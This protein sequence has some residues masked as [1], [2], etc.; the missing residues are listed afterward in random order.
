MRQGILRRYV[1]EHRLL[2]IWWQA[3]RRVQ[4]VSAINGITSLVHKAIRVVVQVQADGQHVVP[5]KDPDIIQQPSHL[6]GHYQPP[7][8]LPVL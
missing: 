2:E 5:H 1:T 8:H 6:Q 4:Q 3:G 7:H